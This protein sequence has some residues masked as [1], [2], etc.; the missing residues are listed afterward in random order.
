MPNKISKR[1][2]AIVKYSTYVFIALLPLL[3]LPTSSI[4]LGQVKIG[5][6]ILYVVIT[7]I[8]LSVSAFYSGRVALISKKVLIPVVL[9]SFVTFL[10]SVFSTSYV[11]G[12]IGTGTEIDSWFLVS[13]FLVIS[14]FVPSI[15]N[16]KEKIF[17]AL[18]VFWI[19]F[20]LSSLFQIIRF[21]A[22]GLKWEGISNF[23][24]LGGVFVSPVLNTV[25]TWGDLGLV[26]GV[27]ALS[28]AITL[29]MIPLK[30]S[31][32]NMFWFLFSMSALISFIASSIFIGSGIDQLT[33]GSR[34]IVPSM[35]VV[36]LL[37][38]CFAVFQLRHKRRE[39]KELKISRISET[40]GTSEETTSR[41]KNPTQK[42]SLPIK[43]PIASF[44]LI[45]LGLIVI[46]SPLAINQKINSWIDVPNE[47][48]LNIRPGISDTYLVSKS[49]IS[50][51]FKNALLGVGPHGF[52][53]AW[54]QYRPDYINKL[55]LWNSDYQFGVG[56]L[57]TTIVNNG[58]LG[59]LL[60]VLSLTALFVAGVISLL[61]RHRIKA[62]VEKDLMS[63]YI[64]IVTFLS[65]L[66]LWSDMKLNTSGS[67]VVILTFIFTGLMLS[68]LVV[69]K[70]I[71]RREY[72]F[73]EDLGEDKFL[74][75]AM[76]KK[77]AGV[78]IVVLLL[79]LMLY[80]TF[81]WIQRTRAQFY[82]TKAMLMVYAKNA[83]ISV[84]PKAMF[85]LQKAFDIHHSD[86]YTKGIN[87][88]AL[89]QVNY[90]FSSDPANQDI[91]ALQNG[92]QIKL[93]SSTAAYLEAAVSS[94]RVGVELNPNDFR[95]FL[96]FGSTMQTVSLLTT[97]PN[98]AKLALQSFSQAIK[99]V[100]NHPLPLYSLANLYVLAGD[101][102]SAKAV[103]TQTL[104]VK[105]NFNEASDLYQRILNEAK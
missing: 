55:N 62:G 76:L 104:K 46:I 14:I 102:E 73:N 95:N 47:S 71:N 105:P 75:K 98:A 33:N 89:V 91:K 30:K 13:I 41:E 45:V 80:S 94:S 82:S 39:A 44:I 1:F 6:A 81:T 52:Y 4:L 78:M 12:L 83:D 42:N 61:R 97:D 93:S 103:L 40:S 64:M 56:Y 7:A 17:T 100:P 86:I 53:I 15:V 32:K 60:W 68:S 99:M 29:D 48:V 37:A 5:L 74:S 54:N 79:I 65:T 3:F 57:L 90:D 43:F 19:S 10:S 24:S 38:L 58:I 8:S 49:V 21:L 23:L 77:K 96:Q 63:T 70:K 66:L 35:S 2:D 18:S 34:L 20:G 92:K 59:F 50:S 11:G 88:L 36:G 69:N 25:G 85:L 9:I 31:L 27:S 22:S 101:K 28:L 16:T 51:S 72:L 84:V 26:A 87:N 67:T